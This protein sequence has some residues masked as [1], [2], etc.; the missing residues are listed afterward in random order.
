MKPAMTGMLSL[1]MDVQ[2][3]VCAKSVATAESIKARFV[4]MATSSRPT[5]VPVP[6]LLHG[7]VTASFAAISP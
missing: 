5:P 7:A 3:V 1:A 6:A 4:T 2:T